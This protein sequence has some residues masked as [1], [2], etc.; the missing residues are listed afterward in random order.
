MLCV[1]F[2]RFKSKDFLLVGGPV[3]VEFLE[4]QQNT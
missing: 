3:G 1:L 2:E 4:F